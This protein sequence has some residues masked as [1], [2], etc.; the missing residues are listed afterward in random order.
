[1]KKVLLSMLAI[2]MVSFSLM[3]QNTDFTTKLKSKYEKQSVVQDITDHSNNAVL[4]ATN[5][6]S[7][8]ADLNGLL[9]AGE[10]NTQSSMIFDNTTATVSMDEVDFGF[11][12]FYEGTLENSM[13]FTFTGDGNRYFIE[14]ADCG[15]TNYA[16]DLQMVVYS[17]TSCMDLTAVACNEDIS[18]PAQLEP[19]VT[20]STEMGVTYFVMID[21]FAGTVGEYCINVTDIG[22]PITCM[23]IAV[24]MVD[25]TNGDSICFLDT[26]AF[27][28]VG[29]VV[30]PEL[31]MGLN[32][33][34]WA[35]ST[36]D[37]SGSTDPFN[38]VSFLGSFGGILTEPIDI[39]VVYDAGL[40]IAD[41]TF[42]IT[43]IVLGGAV[44]TD[45]TF[46]GL[47]F[48]DGC[49]LT[50]TSVEF[51]LL[52]TFDPLTAGADVVG[53]VTPPGMNGEATV[54]PSGGSG[55]YSY[56][57]DNGET[58][59]T[60]TGLAAGTYSVTVSDNGNVCVPDFVLEVEVP[61]GAGINCDSIAVGTAVIES[62]TLCF[63]D[64]LIFSITDGTVIPE[65]QTGLNGFIWAVH[66]SDVSGSDSPFTDLSFLG[67]FGGIQ[68][69]VFDVS[70]VYDANLGLGEGTYYLT[71]IV[72]GGAEDTD[73]TFSGLDFTNGCVLTGTSVE[74]I[75]LPEYPDPVVSTASVDEIT[76]PGNNGE[77]SV[78]AT[79]GSGDF[80]YLWSNGETT[81]SITG[82]PAGTYM[83]T[84]TDES[85]CFDPIVEEVVVDQ[86]VDVDEIPG[87]RYLDV[88]PNPADVQ[89][90][91][92]YAFE[93]PLDIQIIMTNSLGQTVYVNEIDQAIDGNLEIGLNDFT[94]GV[95][96]IRITDGNQQN[97]RRLIISK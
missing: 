9:G 18:Y 65:L 24:G 28:H 7:S 21:G 61:E 25:L 38:D 22:N 91:V 52:P 72:I 79:D 93:Q 55:D 51:E 71:P 46:G 87:T 77:A 69:A 30:I 85:G 70:T 43:P 92:S 84:I 64:S 76:P 19:G 83:V 42:F 17:G 74:V 33:F 13:W 12:C 6:C 68:G 44:D 59:A 88:F 54:I 32:G 96:F 3:A 48:T 37:I 31:D 56:L 4:V 78:N 41:G 36:A 40:G 80:T 82:L 95:Y 58:T 16:A 10:G 66:T 81:A 8:A 47:D 29:D 11:D 63:G 67:A 27:T 89:A 53:E 20:I 2:F 86:I 14:T 15:V 94:N 75:L 73:G 39:S 45:G 26:L 23:D 97:I 50:G 34:V 35:V 62:T 5:D 57:W 49:I 60:I 1:M 90:V